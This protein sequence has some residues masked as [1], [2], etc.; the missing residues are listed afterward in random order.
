MRFDICCNKEI[1]EW[2][3]GR[4]TT[5]CG[6]Q[7]WLRLCVCVVVGP[8]A[9]TAHQP[10]VVV[11]VQ[12]TG[13]SSLSTRACSR[14]CPPA[15]LSTSSVISRLSLS[16]STVSCLVAMRYSAVCTTE[17]AENFVLNTRVCAVAS[18]RRQY[19]GRG[20]KSRRRRCQERDAAVGW[21]IQWGYPPFQP[22]RGSAEAS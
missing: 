16:H 12:S 11:V 18:I 8:P 3:N 6:N 10:S 4:T 17:P 13:R 7:A 15:R 22:S 14:A 1:N 20:R 21:G 5:E 2:M 9:Y 19:E